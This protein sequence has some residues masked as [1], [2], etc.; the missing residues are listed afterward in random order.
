MALRAGRVGVAPDQVNE[1]GKIIGGGSPGPTPPQP[2]GK[3]VYSTTP[4]VVGKWIDGK[5]IYEVVVPLTQNVGAVPD[6]VDTLIYL[7]G[8]GGT[9]SGNLWTVNGVSGLG[10]RAIYYRIADHSI[11][12]GVTGWTCDYGIIQYT[13]EES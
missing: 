2:T 13:K 5:D 8:I 4:Q 11:V 6:I 12:F 10:S 9:D 7:D 1:Q 3:H